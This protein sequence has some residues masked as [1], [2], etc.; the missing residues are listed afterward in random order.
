M[1][2][3]DNKSLLRAYLSVILELALALELVR[4]AKTWSEIALIDIV[5]LI[6]AAKD[7]SIRAVVSRGGRPDLAGMQNEGG[8]EF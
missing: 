3:W 1:I 2:G 5:A 8:W 4:S 6:A 7:H